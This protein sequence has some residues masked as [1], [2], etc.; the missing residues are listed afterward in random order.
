VKRDGRARWVMAALLGGGLA[1]AVHLL[2]S[3]AVVTLGCATGWGGTGL[4]LGA[5]T[6]VCGAVAVATGV[7]AHRARRSAAAPPA[8]LSGPGE[9][10]RFALA[11]G[12][13][14]A[15]LFAVL[16][17]LGGLIPLLVPLCAVSS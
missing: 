16:I 3:Y 8:A 12:T 15:A 1:W 5:I 6:A 10:M 9:P 11:V 14:L 7:A 13:G 2:A 17:A 4:L